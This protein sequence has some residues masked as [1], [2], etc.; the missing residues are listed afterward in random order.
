MKI[1]FKHRADYYFWAF[2]LAVIIKG[3]LEFLFFGNEMLDINI[4]DTYYVASGL[5]V[6]L[7][8]AF[9]FAIIGGIYSGLYAAGVPLVKKL[10]KL[11]TAACMMIFILAWLSLPVLEHYYANSLFDVP[12][13]GDTNLMLLLFLTAFILMQLLLLVNATIGIIKKLR[14]GN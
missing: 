10:T 13:Y 14:A 2:A 7:F 3:L 9:V 8:N 12:W 4:H 11:H 5:H 1:T 6:T